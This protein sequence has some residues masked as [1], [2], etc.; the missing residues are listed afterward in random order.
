LRP[1]KRKR[2]S[3]TQWPSL[4]GKK[5]PEPRISNKKDN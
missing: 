2:E 1:R 5:T 4:I 3:A